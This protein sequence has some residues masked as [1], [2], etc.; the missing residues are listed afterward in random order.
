M[1]DT[2]V[3][4]VETLDQ[5][6]AGNEDAAEEDDTNQSE[7]QPS[8]AAS[9]STTLEAPAAY[10]AE[11]PTLLQRVYAPIRQATGNIRRRRQ[12]AVSGT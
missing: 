5:A 7:V 2:A 10:R 12:S 1:I 6:S 3:E 11:S 8:A 4:M 9:G